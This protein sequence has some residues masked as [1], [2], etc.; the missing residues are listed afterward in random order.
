M[1]SRLKAD[2]LR[3][4]SLHGNRLLVAREVMGSEEGQSASIIDNFVPI[5][6]QHSWSLTQKTRHNL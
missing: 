4:A 3:E 5:A 2:V 1:E 6:G